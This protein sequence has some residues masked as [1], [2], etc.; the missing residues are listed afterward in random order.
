MESEFVHLKLHTEYSLL[1][2]VG[3]IDEY[4]RKASELGMTSLAITDVN[5]FGAIEFFK[6]CKNAKIK[7][8][9]GLEI[10]LDGLEN[11]GE[12]S[13]TLLAKNKNGYKNLCK[14]SSIS[15]EKFS[16]KRNKVKYEDLKQY[17]QDLYILSGGVN[18]E[19]TK[20][21]LDKKNEIAR[22]IMQKFSFDFDKNFFLEIPAEKKLEKVKKLLIETV[23]REE[24]SNFV[25]TNDIYYL[26][27]EDKILQKIVEL[28][29]DG[30][31]SDSEKIVNS[32]EIKN[33]DFYFKNYIEMKNSFENENEIFEKAIENIQKI[34]ENCEVDF[35]FHKFKFPKYELPKNISEKEFLRKLVYNGVVKRYS[36]ASFEVE[37]EEDIQE[38]IKKFSSKKF[39]NEKN[40]D[41]KSIIKRAEYELKIIDEMGY[42]GYFIIVWDFIKFS[43]ENGIYVG[44]GRGS[45]A[46]SIVSYAL[47]I[48]DI[49]PLEYNLIFERFL[50]PERISMPDIDI[51][52][53]QE[54]REQV[55][56][57]VYKKYGSEHVAHIITFGTLKA[58]LVIR[59][60]GRVLNVKISKVDKIAKMIPFSMDLSEAKENVAELKMMYEIDRETREIID[61][62]LKLEGQVRHTS[63][64]AAGIVIS[65]D[66]LTDEIPTYSDGKTKVV[67]TQYQMKELEELG[68]LKMDFLG[69][70]NL[71]I[72]RKTVENVEESKKYNEI[73]FEKS[74]NKVFLDK[75][76]LD[77]KKT[78]ELLSNADTM[79][80]FQCES[81]GIRSLMKKMKVESF[82]D[83][84]A[85]LAL[86][87][88]GP[89][90][91]GMVDDFIS[92][93]NSKNEIKYID[94][95]LKDILAES[96]GMILYQEQVM[97]ILSELAGYTLGE[98]DEVRRAISKK[99]LELIQK[100]REKFVKNTLKKGVLQSENPQKKAN[101]IYDLIEKFGGYGFNK[102]H[103]AAYS[104]IVYWTAFFKANYPLEF[105][106]AIMSVEVSNLD[107]FRIFVNEAKKKN[108]NLLLPD[109][110]FCNKN[111]KVIK[112]ENGQGESIRFG[113]AG[114][115]GIGEKFVKILCEE[116]KN[117]K[118]SSYKDFAQRMRD[119]G[120]TAKQLEILILSGALDKLEKT[121]N[122]KFELIKNFELLDAD[123]EVNGSLFEDLNFKDEKISNSKNLKNT[124]LKNTKFSKAELLEN[125]KKYLGIYVSKHP[126]DLKK[127][128]IE[129]ISH[130]KIKNIF[131]KNLKNVRVIGILKNLNIFYTKKREQ[132]AKFELED[133]D[134]SIKVICFPNK[135]GN[136]ENEIKEN[137]IV[138]LEGNVNFE[139]EKYNIFLENICKLEN[140][141][142]RQDLKL[143]IKI[144]ED[145]I[146]KSKEIKNLMLKYRGKNKFI[147]FLEKNG[148]IELKTSKYGISISL[149]FL[150]RLVKLVGER[151]IKIK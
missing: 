126:L 22:K 21:I 122:E 24:I 40:L 130:N 57:Y 11:F 36:L 106:A 4:V 23:K 50:N 53:D 84:V 114:V 100:N 28:I 144:D 54:Q 3:K 38:V 1:E 123:T 118:F 61:Y 47:N 113:F 97:K 104:L 77:N 29:K 81:V 103:S 96:Y 69:L 140:L 101:E 20:C 119:N 87:R 86:Y 73:F 147:Q 102:S 91:S 33:N 146:K 13:L 27:E 48:T 70:K 42:N 115:K 151:K 37:N 30:E 120:M 138:I 89:L 110:N 18:G 39:K 142:K 117:G 72:L 92:Q 14:L 131:K 66:V 71:T 44:P 90:G 55:I 80:V 127:V 17:S 45:A 15:F 74:K 9:I 31:K 132:M 135:Y 93:K 150:R 49:D 125:E 51:D 34:V 137:E 79:G 82:S 60:V 88:P 64:H 43:R 112:N 5:M 6:K 58:R 111:F 68:I 136:F 83:I 41:G 26:S 16:R 46:G 25:V 107:R 148:K 63:I 52:F 133:F 99:N 2:S 85:L 12:Y 32:E 76:P 121:R 95:S 108:I 78:Y 134:G 8:I 35:E 98:A 139:N 145:T 67:A 116:L 109:V 141:E 124:K 128:L 94:G 10:F 105:F 56:D 129:R 19:I 143:F 65:K 75:I 149:N 62:S 59:D 7:P